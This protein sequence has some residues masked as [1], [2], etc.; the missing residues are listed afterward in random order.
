MSFAVTPAE[1]RREPLEP[2]A[3]ALL[4]AQQM[5]IWL[6]TDRL[7]AA[8]F[9][10]QWVA[11]MAAA[12]WLT[13]R[14]WSGRQ[15]TTQPP[16][17]DVGLRGRRPCSRT[18]RPR[19]VAPRPRGD[20]S[21]HRR[22]ADADVRPPDPADRRTHRISLPRLRVACLPVVLPRLDSLRPGHDRRRRRS[23]SARLV[24]AAVDLRRPDGQPV[25]LGGARR[26]G[27]VRERLF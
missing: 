16:P 1:T 5:R 8:L 11:A 18:M 10:V 26:L 22:R 4:R 14:T 19:A 15:S 12:L 7:F 21:C 6:Q 23:F 20:A 24:V 27:R 9:L 25:A 3:A 13:P 17:V 2:R